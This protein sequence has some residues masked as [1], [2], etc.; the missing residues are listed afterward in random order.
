M[1]KARLKRV[2][3]LKKKRSPLARLRAR[4][5]KSRTSKIEKA[6][7]RLLKP[8]GFKPNV[9]VG[10]YVVDAFHKEKKLIVEVD[11]DYWHGNPAVYSDDDVIKPLKITVGQKHKMDA[12]R[13]N[14][15]R[16]MGFN[17]ISFWEKDLRRDM[18]IVLRHP[19]I[20][21]VSGSE[22]VDK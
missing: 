12:R 20:E 11:G 6:V 9:R 10:R 21:A 13:V 16:R 7:F 14:A 15:L 5:L 4:L 8:L 1:S 22:I 2:E 18:G 17:V 3:R 19:I